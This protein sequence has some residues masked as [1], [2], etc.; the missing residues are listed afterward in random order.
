M[1]CCYCYFRLDELEKLLQENIQEKETGSSDREDE[2]VT[3]EDLSEEHRSKTNTIPKPVKPSSSLCFPCLFF[4][5]SLS[6]HQ[7][8]LMCLV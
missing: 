3:D 5:I 1:F 2:N 6:F 4:L 8:L 7:L